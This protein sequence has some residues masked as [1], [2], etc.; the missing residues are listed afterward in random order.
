MHTNY[1]LEING[2][3]KHYSNFQL[4]DVSLTLPKGTIVGFI[5][6]N[7][8]GKTTTIKLILNQVKKQSGSIVVLGLDH[9]KNEREI[10]EQ[11]GVVLDEGFFYDAMNPLNFR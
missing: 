8:A 2:L 4:D 3:T 6:A 7:G 10:K 1:A 9:E 5:G 11:L